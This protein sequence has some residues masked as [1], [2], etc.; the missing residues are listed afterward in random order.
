MAAEE[1]GGG[2]SPRG[3]GTW[4]GGFLDE[5]TMQ[6]SLEGPVEEGIIQ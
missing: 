4:W 3:G 6:W 1:H 5:V 2:R